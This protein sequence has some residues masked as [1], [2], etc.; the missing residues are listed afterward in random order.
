MMLL[1]A[2]RLLS[3]FL[4]KIARRAQPML[5]ILGALL[6][7]GF[8]VA[9]SVVTAR[10]TDPTDRYDHGVLGDAIEWGT[11]EITL[12]DGTKRRFI[13]PETL[14]F[15]DVAPRVADLDADG[16]P[17]IIVV[18]SS[19]TLGARLAVYGPM[20]RLAMTD[21]IGRKNRWLA[22]VGAADF[23]GD[24][25]SEIAMVVTPHLAG[26][27]E[28]LVFDGTHL[29]P[30]ATTNGLTNHRIGDMDIAGGIRI[31]QD[32]PQIILAQMPWRASVDTTMVAVRL[33][34]ETLQAA[35]F[36]ESFTSENVAKARNCEIHP[37]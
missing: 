24:G 9:D 18:E 26:K 20:G 21:H 37:H 11:L 16:S 1:E 30:I 7:P 27:L 34:G 3:R 22:P 5:C 12:E 23:T 8:A 28:I 17:E 4:N 13:L 10:Y 19:L 15:E 14:V 36:K 2:R 31:C 35:S 33:I 25:R 32:A 6:V 29:T